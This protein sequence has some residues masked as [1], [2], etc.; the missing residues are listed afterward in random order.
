[1]R[2]RLTEDKPTL[3]IDQ[4]GQPIQASSA[5]ELAE[6]AG[7]GRVAKMYSDKKNGR[8]MWTGYVVGRRWFTAFKWQE[9]TP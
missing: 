8:T 7:G 2:N 9:V 6:R 5:K 1:M 4:H 3:F